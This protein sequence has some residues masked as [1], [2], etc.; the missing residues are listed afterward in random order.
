MSAVIAFIIRVLALF[1]VSLSPSAAGAIVAGGVALLLGGGSLALYAKGY[2]AADAKCDAAALQSK[3]DV[4]EAD[5]D[6]ARRALADARLR[7]ASIELQA[8]ADKEGTAVYVEQLKTR[9][10]SAC[11]ITDDDL[12]G[13][14]IKPPGG[15]AKG[16]AAG[17]R[18]LD[19]ARRGAKGGEG[20]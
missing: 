8:N 4:L 10:A 14:R 6:A 12:R 3:I 5:R 20:R 19:A 17:K 16:I 18:F 7:A 15:A 13:M 11:A 2:A 1:G 9:F